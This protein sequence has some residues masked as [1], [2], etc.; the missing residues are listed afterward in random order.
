MAPPPIPDLKII[1]PYHGDNGDVLL[2]SAG[3]DDPNAYASMIHFFNRA[4]WETNS[5]AITRC[6]QNLARDAVNL[7]G[8]YVQP[9]DSVIDVRENY[10]RAEDK[11]IIVTP[12]PSTGIVH[13]FIGFRCQDPDVATNKG[14]LVGSYGNS[15]VKGWGL[16]VDSTGRLRLTSFDAGGTSRSCDKATY[17][18]DAMRRWRVVEYKITPTQMSLLDLTDGLAATT[19]A[20][21]G[22]FIGQQTVAYFGRQ[23]SGADFSG[24]KDVAMNILLS[25][26]GP[27]VLAAQALELFG[28]TGLVIGSAD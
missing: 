5:E 18:G 27:P 4:P 28:E 1:N 25:Q 7:P 12:A 22:H 24:H 26:V 9:E 2:R 11:D 16:Y 13:G 20:I 19:L 10:W 6:V 15:G 21:T 14:F 23:T 8:K 17:S 3:A